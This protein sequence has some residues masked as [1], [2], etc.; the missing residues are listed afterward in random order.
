MNLEKQIN[1]VFY[2]YE[3]ERKTRVMDF[4]AKTL[5]SEL[6]D[7]QTA[8]KGAK[9]R[10]AT[11]YSS[12][13]E[14]G[15]SG[16]DLSQKLTKAKAKNAALKAQIQEMQK[17]QQYKF[18]EL[19]AKAAKYDTE[20]AIL[21][22]YKAKI[23]KALNQKVDCQNCKTLSAEVTELRE[24]LKTKEME[25]SELL[26][27]NKRLRDELHVTSLQYALYCFIRIHE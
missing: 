20:V 10:Y 14:T 4:E 16:S 12:Q 13:Y 21:Q 23:Q 1:D 19:E 7:D 25:L 2:A 3:S 6:E 11:H 24:A 5:K 26:L 8:L 22:T 15:N 9:R 17:E 27:A 18:Q